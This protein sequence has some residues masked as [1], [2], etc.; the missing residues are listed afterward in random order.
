MECIEQLI[1][2]ETIHEEVKHHKRNLSEAWINPRMVYDCVYKK[3]STEGLKLWDVPK[4]IVEVVEKASNNW[5][6]RLLIR[7]IAIFVAALF[8]LPPYYGK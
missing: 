7:G 5:S 3:W 2:D 6:T 4:W 8:Q 1:V